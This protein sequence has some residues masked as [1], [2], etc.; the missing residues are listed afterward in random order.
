MRL[1]ALSWVDLAGLV[2]SLSGWVVR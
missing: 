2:K 1:F